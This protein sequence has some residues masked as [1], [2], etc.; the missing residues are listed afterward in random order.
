MNKEEP[1]ILQQ[2]RLTGQSLQAI[3]VN[4]IKVSRQMIPLRT[5]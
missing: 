3:R 2:I 5:L 4:V 1:Q